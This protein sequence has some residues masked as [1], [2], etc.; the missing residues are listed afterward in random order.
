MHYIDGES[1][2]KSSGVGAVLQSSDSFEIEYAME[3]DYLITN[4][5]A[6]Y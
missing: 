3:L 5:G 1:K 4:N 6:E 2:P